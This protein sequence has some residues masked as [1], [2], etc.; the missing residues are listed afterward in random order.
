LKDTGQTKDE[1][2]EAVKLRLQFRR[3]CT[4]VTAVVD[5]DMPA[6]EGNRESLVQILPLLTITVA[7]SVKFCWILMVLTVDV[8]LTG[9]SAFPDGILDVGLRGLNVTA[10]LGPIGAFSLGSWCCR[11]VLKTQLLRPLGHCLSIGGCYWQAPWMFL[12]CCQMRQAS[13]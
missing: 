8:L 12:G 3:R 9:W 4:F 7:P 13:C 1:W 11:C 10:D 5:V 2:Q 6:I